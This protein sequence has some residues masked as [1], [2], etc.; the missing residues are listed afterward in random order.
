MHVNTA[1]MLPHY[2]LFSTTPSFS[3]FVVHTVATIYLILHL[4]LMFSAPG[5]Q[6]NEIVSNQ[7][8]PNV[9]VVSKERTDAVDESSNVVDLSTNTEN[10]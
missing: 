2:F 4:H 9:N 7:N 8:H 6:N 3:T 1:S 10:I 5:M